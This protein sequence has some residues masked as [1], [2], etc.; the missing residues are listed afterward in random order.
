MSSASLPVAVLLVLFA[1]LV[2]L[3]AWKESNL[4]WQGVKDGITGFVKVAPMMLVAF[5][6][7]A[8]ITRLVP[9]ESFVHWLGKN[10]GWRGLGL[11]TLAGF[12]TPGGPFIQFPI[13]AALYE[14]GVAVGPLAAYLSAW[15]L[16]GVHRFF[17]FE[18]PLL[19]WKFSL[20]RFALSCAFPP[21]IGWLTHW[22]WSRWMD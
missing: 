14:R 16:L 22:V 9:Q 18:V 2:G 1:A 7:A 11:A 19:G 21:L 10:S 17:I 5:C 20:C 12:L 13:V 6:A 3:A 4:P 8:L 15:S